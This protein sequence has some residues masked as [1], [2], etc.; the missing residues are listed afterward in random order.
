M[1][2]V[3]I[4]LLHNKLSKDTSFVG[5]V[6]ALWTRSKYF[7]TEIVINGYRVI[8]NPGQG[9]VID[10]ST[11]DDIEN[12]DVTTFPEFSITVGEYEKIFKWLW[13][14]EGKGYDIKGILFSQ[15]FKFSTHNHD[16]WFCSEIATTILQLFNVSKS[17]G[18]IPNNVSP[19]ILGNIYNSGD[20]S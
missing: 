13:D 4:S 7:H 10:R 11:P 3:R 16:K 19:A 12:W 2:T 14:Q 8:S 20:K 6:I 9:L 5:K 18:L 15:I 17:E 1:K